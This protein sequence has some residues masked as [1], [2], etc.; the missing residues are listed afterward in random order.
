[1][2]TQPKQM[3]TSSTAK[4]RRTNSY[5]FRTTLRPNWFITDAV[6][7]GDSILNLAG[8]I[9]QYTVSGKPSHVPVNPSRWKEAPHRFFANL[10]TVETPDFN[11]AI[12]EPNAMAAFV[13]RYGLL[14][15][16]F[17]N[18]NDEE[19]T[20]RNRWGHVVESF[21]SLADLIESQAHWGAAEFQEQADLNSLALL[22]FAWR[23]GDKRAIAAIARCA[24][25]GLTSEI[26]QKTGEV[27]INVRDVWSLICLL[28]VRDSVAGKTAIC[29]NP[30]CLAP[31]F[32]KNRR[33]QKICDTG[34]CKAWATRGYALKWWHENRGREKEGGK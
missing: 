17:D 10:G 30:D 9:A 28:F 24:E 6:E 3:K 33:T 15:V 14:K 20:K 12:I 27:A 25:A 22:Q 32:L 2:V 13:K 29:A 1:M 5:K 4:H 8:G 11:Q 23:F 31:Y 21:S 18:R 7:V 34:P 26:E 16:S 19:F